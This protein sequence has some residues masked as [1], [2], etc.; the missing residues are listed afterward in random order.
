[1]SKHTKVI[2]ML[3]ANKPNWEIHA[4]VLGR[5][6]IPKLPFRQ[7]G[8]PTTSL[9]SRIVW[10]D[11]GTSPIWPQ[12]I[13]RRGTNP[14][15]QADWH[16]SRQLLRPPASWYSLRYSAVTVP[17]RCHSRVSLTF[18]RKQPR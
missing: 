17:A 11:L 5:R 1:I 3:R 8:L 13:Q 16:P 12:S 14:R 10:Q 18:L 15:R 7:V 6:S 2:A 4:L 9:G